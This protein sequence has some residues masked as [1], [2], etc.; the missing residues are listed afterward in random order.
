MQRISA[1]ILPE[2]LICSSC[3]RPIRLEKNKPRDR[4]R[5]QTADDDFA[6]ARG[7]SQSSRTIAGFEVRQRLGS[8]TFGEVYRAYDPELDRDVALKLPTA[9]TLKSKKS[10]ERFLREAKA[11][12]RLRHPNIVPVFKAGRIGDQY[13][14]ASAFIDGKSLAEEMDGH[15]LEFRRAAAIVQKLAHALHYA[16]ENGIVHRDVK[17]DNVMLDGR[18]EPQL[19]DFG[20]ARLEES[21][22]KFTQD[23]HV[24]GTPAYMA[25]EQ[26]AGKQDEIGPASDQYSIGV[27][28]YELLTGQTPF[29]GTTAAVVLFHAANSEAPPPATINANIPRDLETICQKAMAKEIGDRYATCEVLAKDLQ[30][31][32]DDKPISARPLTAL[33]RVHR[34]ARRNPTIAGLVGTVAILLFGTA[35]LSTVFAARLELERSRTEAKAIEATEQKQIAEVKATEAFRE[36]QS[37]DQ[38]RQQ[39]EQK[40]K[41][42]DKK[43]E[44]AMAAKQ[45][46][47]QRTAEAI[48][49]TENAD[50]ARIRAEEQFRNT[51]GIYYRAEMT[52]ASRDLQSRDFDRVRRRLQRTVPDKTAGIDLRGFE[53]HYFD[54]LCRSARA[55]LKEHEQ[56]VTDVAFSPDG[57][58]LASA[59]EDRKILIWDVGDWKLLR[60]L[61]GHSSHVT[62][63]DFSPDGQHLVSAGYDKNII[64]WDAQTGKKL[65]T[66]RGNRLKPKATVRAHTEGLMGVTFSPNGKQI[67]TWSRD[68]SVCLWEVE[69]GELLVNLSD[70]ESVPTDVAFSPDS[71]H[72]AVASNPSRIWDI[73]SGTVT[74]RLA[75]RSSTVDYSPNGQWLLTAAGSKWAAWNPATGEQLWTATIGPYVRDLVFSPNGERIATV[76]SH[77]GSVQIWDAESREQLAAYVGHRE[78]A[79]TVGFSSDGKLIASGSQDGTVQIWDATPQTTV[80]L[81]IP[82]SALDIA[83]SPKGRLLAYAQSREIGLW[84]LDATM[85]ATKFEGSQ[86]VAFRPNAAELAFA[87]GG[88]VRIRGL[89]TGQIEQEFDLLG[90]THAIAFS[91]DGQKL[92]AGSWKTNKVQIWDADTAEE[93]WTI[94]SEISQIY[95]IAFSPDSRRLA[96]AGYRPNV[97]NVWDFEE[98]QKVFT[99][100][101]HFDRLYDVEFSADGQRLASIDG[102]GVL[103]LWNAASGQEIRTMRNQSGYA[104]AFSPDGRRLVI[105]GASKTLRIFDGTT[106]DELFS[107]DNAPSNPT[108]IVFS[109]DGG[110]IAAAGQGKMIHLWNA[111]PLAN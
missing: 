13:Y 76:G 4:S 2:T 71:Q 108:T 25:P 9:N 23:G 17:P 16:H 28:L 83:F 51:V 27:V 30:H 103:K 75:V 105:G 100:S 43:A 7:L 15:R 101:G 79:A 42:A 31:Y 65:Q 38:A 109:A 61:E 18:D 91:H 98:R 88:K 19:M 60:T 85:P 22:E 84:N 102:D 57:K 10:R 86:R 80:P 47:E 33:Q 46:A 1:E 106:G 49:Q 36:R 3:G 50:A 21:T 111:T 97:V 20:I 5:S 11:A 41:D 55:T 37:A 35:V 63:I 58:L 110:V 94:D 64:L 107:L 81:Q 24:L 73:A 48:R 26:A 59:G 70:H 29:S 90:D 53:W 62:G 87:N 66:L 39:A 32:L 78:I 40:R 34:W 67:A 14:I 96:V 52:L 77:D 8:G 12:A 95:A 44:A 93:L 54:R 6:N 45:V 82:V 74:T 89:A 92:A 99:L 56:A 72:V 68:K 104:L 69:S